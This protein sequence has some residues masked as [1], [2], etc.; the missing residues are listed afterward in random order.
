MSF[1]DDG[2]SNEQLQL[3]V[4]DEAERRLTANH[5]PRQTEACGRPTGA[6]LIVTLLTCPPRFAVICPDLARFTRPHTQSA[7]IKAI[8]HPVAPLKPVCP[9]GRSFLPGPAAFLFLCGRDHNNWAVHEAFCVQAL[10][11]FA[12]WRRNASRRLRLGRQRSALQSL[13]RRRRLS[14]DDL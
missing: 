2:C 3:A 6:A 7:I 13:E 14:L 10:A 9:S 12:A 5:R 8:R 4:A 11:A 1:F